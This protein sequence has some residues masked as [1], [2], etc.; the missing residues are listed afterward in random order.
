ME[1]V[2]GKNIDWKNKLDNS[3]FIELKT[4]LKR[5]HEIDN[6]IFNIQTKVKLKR[7][8][9][10]LEDHQQKKFLDDCSKS[11]SNL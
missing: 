11:F 6:E 3:K 4:L 1:I 10:E 2:K 5:L 8:I 9:S 7:F